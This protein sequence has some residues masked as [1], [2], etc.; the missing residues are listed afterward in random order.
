M[1]VQVIDYIRSNPGA[2]SVKYSVRYLFPGLAIASLLWFTGCGDA[3]SPVAP[4]TATDHAAFAG[5]GQSFFVVSGPDVQP[6]GKTAGRGKKGKKG[7]ATTVTAGGA[8]TVTEI[9]GKGGGTLFVSTDGPLKHDD[10]EVTFT[11]PRNAIPK[12]KPWK[13]EVPISMSVSGASLSELVIS[14]DPSGLYFLKSAQLE[15]KAQKDFVGDVDPNEILIIH[16]SEG[17]GEPVPFEVKV[18]R[19]TVTIKVQADG[20]SRYSL[21]PGA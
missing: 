1:T 6:A 4:E 11:I 9:I 3:S 12:E 21:P 16:F 13:G 10:L 19:G 14:F 8:T 2:F 5:G 7:G 17:T 18:K 20:F 15:I